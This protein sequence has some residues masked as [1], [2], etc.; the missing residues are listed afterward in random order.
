MTKSKHKAIYEI[1][2]RAVGKDGKRKTERDLVEYEGRI[3]EVAK[4]CAAYYEGCDAEML[5]IYLSPVKEVYPPKDGNAPTKWFTAKLCER[6]EDPSTG[7]ETALNYC[8]MLAAKDFEDASEYAK[9][10]SQQ[11]YG[12]ELVSLR[13]SGVA[14][15]IS[16]AEI[17]GGKASERGY[18][19]VDHD[20]IAADHEWGDKA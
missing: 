15:L 7:K 9:E 4:L 11:G 17:L 10:I 16:N 14:W 19:E 8:I 6:S 2:L 12:M 5:A 18:A 1:K 3:E 20:R 13:P